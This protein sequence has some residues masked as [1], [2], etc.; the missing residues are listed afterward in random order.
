MRRGTTLI[1]LMVVMAIWAAVMSAVLGFYI[2]G[3]KVSRRQDVLSRQLREVQMLYDRIVGRITNAVIRE[4][5]LGNQP[6]IVY[7]RTRTEDAL[8]INGLLPNWTPQDEIL[9]IVPQDPAF[10]G[11]LCFQNQLVV[12]ENNQ[13]SVLMKLPVGML[14]SFEQVAPDILMQVK[15]PALSSQ[16]PDLKTVDVTSMYEDRRWRKITR[17][18][19]LNGWK[20]HS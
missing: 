3:T 13:V 12:Q 20:G 15:V 9:A 5:H 1:E 2:Y 10:S 11:P 19:L 16:A 17:C 14:V 7:V 8:L 18:F 4:V 6:V